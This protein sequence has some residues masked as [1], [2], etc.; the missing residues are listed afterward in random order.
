MVDENSQEKWLELCE[1]VKKEIM[2]YDDSMKF[3]RYIALRL[4]GLA[5]GKF[6]ANKTQ[7]AQAD[8]SYQT[9]LITF[10]FCKPTIEGYFIKNKG[11]FNDE[12]HKFNYVMVVVENEINDIVM[13]MRNSQKAEEKT[14]NLVLPQQVNDGASYTKKSTKT[15]KKL[16]DL[17]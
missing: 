13:R 10:K 6:M 11:K 5:K 16:E 3:P 1:Y 4:R 12:K 15:D 7:R 2:N 17:W 8:Y 14:Q 9:I